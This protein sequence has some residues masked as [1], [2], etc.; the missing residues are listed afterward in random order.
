[1]SDL[2]DVAQA[3]ADP[4]RRTILAVLASAPARTKQLAGAAGMSVSAL[5]R[6]LTMLRDAHLVERID[7]AGDGRGREYRL[8]PGG[9]DGFGDWMAQT[10]WATS[11]AKTSLAPLTSEL[12][13]RLGA[14][15]DAFA[16]SDRAFFERHLA[17]DVQ[18]IF[19]DA[20]EA[21]DKLGCLEGV[22]EHPAWVRY[23]I[24]PGAVA[25]PLGAHSLLSATA[26]VEHADDSHPRRVF[27]SA[28]F[29][30]SAPWHLLHLQWTSAAP[31]ASESSLT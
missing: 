18:L 13:R 10:R 23:D 25:R 28:C 20:P 21:Y 2:S 4:T 12:L 1:M 16:S 29:H 30:E 8:L 31:T 3:L 15:L 9:L 22:G 14:F 19:P 7:V 6:H 11:L 24:E 27:V 17:D 26:I 5:S